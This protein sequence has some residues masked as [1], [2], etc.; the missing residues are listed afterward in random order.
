MFWFFVIGSILILAVGMFLAV[1]LP[2]L[3]LKVRGKSAAARPGPSKLDRL[4]VRFLIPL[5][6]L[7]L[8]VVAFYFLVQAI[9]WE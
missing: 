8:M 3:Y 5:V 1:G 2:R 6:T 4:V 9:T 7:S